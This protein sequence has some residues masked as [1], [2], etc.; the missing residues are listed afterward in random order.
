[1]LL[2]LFC[3]TFSSVNVFVG[4]VL[5]SNYVLLCNCCCVVHIDFN[6]YTQFGSNLTH[7]DIGSSRNTV[8]V[9]LFA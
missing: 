1:M 2:C 7:F 5:P 8:K 4:D 3:G 9:I 6:P